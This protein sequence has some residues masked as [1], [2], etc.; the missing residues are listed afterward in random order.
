VAR[1]DPERS[2]PARL[3]QATSTDDYV[4]APRSGI[5]EPT[6]EQGSDASEGDLLGRLHDFAD[7]SAAPLEVRAH[8][9]G[10]VMMM[11]FTA[12]C[13]KGVTLYVIGKEYQGGS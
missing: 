9:A 13:P 2:G 8:R 12:V 3:L 11:H 6:V 1:I 5:W 7:H 4:P 10:V